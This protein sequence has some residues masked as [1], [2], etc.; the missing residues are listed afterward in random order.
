MNRHAMEPRFNTFPD[1]A[2]AW[3]ARL[4][5][6]TRGPQD[7]EAF[8]RWRAADPDHAAAFAEVEYLHRNAAMLA[9]DPLLRAVARAARRDLARRP[10]ARPQRTWWLAAGVAA[11]LLVALGLAQMVRNGAPVEQ[12]YATGTGLPQSVTLADGTLVQLDAQS[13]LVA[14]FSAH[15]REVVV[16]NGRAQFHVAHDGARPFLVQVDGNVIRDIGTTFQVSRRADGVTVGLLE[17]RVS[18]SRD[19]VGQTWTS[20]LAPAQQ[21]HI[22]AH[23]RAAGVAPLDLDQARGWTRGELSFDQRRLDRLLQSMNRYSTTQLRLGD[24]ALAS[25]KVSG[26]FHAGDQEAL[27]SALARGWKLRVER[28][29][30]NELTLLPPAAGAH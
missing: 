28:T 29:G 20:N 11:G 1:S 30:A 18:V 12:H 6:P 14:R 9:D 15:Q 27:A 26:S 4:H 13:S 5:S 7:E 21:L 19:T 3:L 8:E 2:E 25:L 24:P 16:R 17:G 23:G 22:D 10:P